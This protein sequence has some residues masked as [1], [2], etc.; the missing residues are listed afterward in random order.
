MKGFKLSAKGENSI[1]KNPKTKQTTDQSLKRKHRCNMLYKKIGKKK[2]LLFLWALG[3]MADSFRLSVMAYVAHLPLLTSKTFGFYYPISK[4]N[5]LIKESPPSW[6]NSIWISIPGQSP[7]ASRP[8]LEGPDFRLQHPFAN[9]GA[10]CGACLRNVM[11]L[12]LHSPLPS[13]QGKLFLPGE[14]LGSEMGES[15]LNSY[16]TRRAE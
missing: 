12:G 7:W 13:F 2:Y 3:Q 4:R 14:L 9:L 15:I 10:D 6:L 16:T 8:G 5:S 11:S 1:W